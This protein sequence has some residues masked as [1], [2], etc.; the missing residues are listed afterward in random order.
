MHSFIKYFEFL[1]ADALENGHYTNHGPA[2]EKAERFMEKHFPKYKVALFGSRLAGIGTSLHTLNVN[3]NISGCLDREYLK[4]YLEFFKVNA[5]I[6]ID[7]NNNSLFI[8][9]TSSKM[10]ADNMGN[11]SIYFSDTKSLSE[12]KKIALQKKPDVIVLFSLKSKKIPLHIQK[13]LDFSCICFK[14][15]NDYLL[16]TQMRSS[17]GSKKFNGDVIATLNG[18]PSEIIGKLVCELIK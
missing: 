11:K 5:N 3:G 8:K 4:T 12:L 9:K 1:T 16:S 13:I 10:K 17:Y 2:V 14:E 6:L 7:T 15:S 18:R